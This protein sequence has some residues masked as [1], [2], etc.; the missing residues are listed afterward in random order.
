MIPYIF[1]KMKTER[2]TSDDSEELRV[3]EHKYKICDM[4]FYYRRRFEP[5]RFTWIEEK[6]REISHR[7]IEIL[8]R[9]KLSP[10]RCII[11]GRKLSWNH[12]YKFCDHCYNMRY[13]I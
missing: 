3:L 2:T 10:R 5:D 11:C 9:Q 6:K 4:L 12:K 13:G 1:T 8:N 7:I